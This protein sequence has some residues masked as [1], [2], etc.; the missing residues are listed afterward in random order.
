MVAEGEIILNINVYYPATFEK[1]RAQNLPNT[2]VFL[3]LIISFHY[4]D[5]F[6]VSPRQFCYVRPHITVLMMGSH[7]LAELRDAICCVNDLQVCGEFSNMPDMAPDFISKVS[8]H[9]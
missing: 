1:V 4:T 6:T 8:T 7:T 9:T 3:G 2:T 5:I